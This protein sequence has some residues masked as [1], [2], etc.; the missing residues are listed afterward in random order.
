MTG[1]F[2]IV[3]PMIRM[4]DAEKAHGA[5]IAA[6]KN[7]LIPAPSTYQHDDLK[8]NLAGL[9]FPNP[10]G[11]APGFD[12]N[13]EVPDAMLKQGFGFVEIG[14]VTPLPQAGNEKPRLFRLPEDKAVI[15]RMGFN[16]HGAETVLKRLT[17]RKGQGIVGVNIG[18]NKMTETR[19]DDY[20]IG[21]E[22]FHQI[23]DY[24][25][26]NISSPNTPGLRAMQSRRELT[27]LLTRLN[28]T[29]N[30]LKST[31]PMFLKI[32]PDLIDDELAEICEVCS[33]GAVEGLIISNTTLSRENL[34]SNR[35]TEAGGLSGQPLF[36]MSTRMLA[37][38]YK[39]TN[40][41][42]PLIGVGGIS[43]AEQAFAK[44][45]AGA[46]LVQLY[47]AMV[48]QGP[49]MANDIAK[50]LVNL[51]AKHNF[52]SIGNAVG[53]DVGGWL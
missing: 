22:T 1:L 35:Q 28:E 53:S 2:N 50:G 11:L 19:E 51:T 8:I 10:V 27:S 4:L 9:N 43:N 23:A 48:Y 39:L 38:A 40:G 24:L 5:A 47:S 7:G 37:S 49:G 13:A 12:K 32:A 6:L 33:N 46:T 34:R 31:T 41:A 26:V 14:T 45:C 16:N 20:V 44:I 25:T 17:A 3:G 42:L 15:N 52:N 21:I 29:R 18:A 30:E 36:E